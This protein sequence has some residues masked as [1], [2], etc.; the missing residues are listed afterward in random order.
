MIKNR[1]L[2]N[3]NPIFDIYLKLLKLSV[4]VLSRHSYID[5]MSNQDTGILQICLIIVPE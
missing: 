2:K 4:A 1:I 3:L 5:L